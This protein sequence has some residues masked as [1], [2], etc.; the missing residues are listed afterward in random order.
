MPT[1]AVSSL[2]S[3]TAPPRQTRR[4]GT[5]D[6][7]VEERLVR[8][9]NLVGKENVIGGTDCGLQRVAHSSIQ[10]A[11]FRAGAEGARIATKQL[12]GK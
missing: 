5:F 11:K 3:A 1:S 8:Y 12:W 7:E 4:T 6:A 10:W 2:L 9:A